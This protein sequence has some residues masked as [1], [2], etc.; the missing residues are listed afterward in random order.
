MR[1]PGFRGATQPAGQPSLLPKQPQ[2]PFTHTLGVTTRRRERPPDTTTFGYQSPPELP[3][4]HR[5]VYKWLASLDMSHNI[6]NPKR[7]MQN[8]FVVAELLQRYFPVSF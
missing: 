4:L 3:A 8:G 5:D 7:D 6:K 1:N 2:M